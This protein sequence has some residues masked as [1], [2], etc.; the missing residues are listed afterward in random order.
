M[1]EEFG[2][3]A[4]E[5]MIE[6]VKD[7]TREVSEYI[8]A[9]P[10]PVN[11]DE[12]MKEDKNMDTEDWWQFNTSELIETSCSVFSPLIPKN[13]KKDLIRGF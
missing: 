1:L 8:E 5:G 11:V 6:H 2:G 12:S 13:A 4:D 9:N 10:I 7:L 3:Y